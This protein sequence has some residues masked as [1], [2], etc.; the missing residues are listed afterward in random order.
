MSMYS[1]NQYKLEIPFF[2]SNYFLN[3]YFTFSLDNLKIYYNNKQGGN[4]NIPNFS[5][6]YDKNRQTL[7]GKEIQAISNQIQNRNYPF[8]YKLSG[9]NEFNKLF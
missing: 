7:Y 1:F 6:I 5:I 2:N 4:A 8:L 3:E 9:K